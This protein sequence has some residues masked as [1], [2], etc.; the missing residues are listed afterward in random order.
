[1]RTSTPSSRLLCRAGAP[2]SR[3]RWRAGTPEAEPDALRETSNVATD[4][5]GEASCPPCIAVSVLDRSHVG[6][7]LECQVLAAAHSKH[8]F[9][10]GR[11]AC[12]R[13]HEGDRRDADSGHVRNGCVYHYRDRCTCKLGLQPRGKRNA[14]SDTADYRD[15]IG[16]RIHQPETVPAR[17]GGGAHRK[18]A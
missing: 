7:L 11:D 10:R 6:R 2:S 1:M 4:A 18:S 16:A 13:H 17:T 5:G 3:S 15:Q 14:R 12:I 8:H 9:D